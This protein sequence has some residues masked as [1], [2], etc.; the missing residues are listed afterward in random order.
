MV[1]LYNFFL[2]KLVFLIVTSI[3]AIKLRLIKTF[4]SKTKNNNYGRRKNSRS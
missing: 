1:K 3:F 2:H 4:Y